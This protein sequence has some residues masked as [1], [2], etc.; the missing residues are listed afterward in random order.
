MKPEAEKLGASSAIPVGV[1]SFKDVELALGEPA[2][3]GTVQKVHDKYASKAD[4]R[5]TGHRQLPASLKIPPAV[6]HDSEISRQGGIKVLRAH[7]ENLSDYSNAFVRLERS[8]EYFQVFATESSNLSI[9]FP[10]PSLLTPC[11]YQEQS[12]GI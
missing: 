9:T 8:S 2:S 7:S 4:K 6:L 1:L 10:H 3:V 11:H 12:I 5:P